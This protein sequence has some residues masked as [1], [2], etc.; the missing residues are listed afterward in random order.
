M[1]K[2]S[3][4]LNKQQQQMLAAGLLCAGAFGY[5]YHSYFWKPR[6]VRI[7][8][9]RRQ[10]EE[11]D[12]GITKAESQAARLPRVEK[13]LELLNQAAA[14]AERRLPLAKDI[15]AVIDTI[16]R[17]ARA[18]KVELTSL[19]PSGTSAKQFFIE[20]PYAVGAVGSYHDIGRFLAAIALEERIFNVRDVTYAGAGKGPLT[21][22]FMLVSY[23]YK[24]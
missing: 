22:N 3:I 6:S 20:V 4:R 11:V 10:I 16:S 13:E 18:Y 7:A 5:I 2:L 12:A 23:Q 17:L 21:V 9:A 8:D 15:P 19:A 24:G 1:A 14:D